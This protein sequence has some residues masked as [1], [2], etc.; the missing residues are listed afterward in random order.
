MA[1][2]AD[3]LIGRAEE[4]DA[5]DAALDRLAHGRSVAVELVGEP[6]IGKT[7]LLIELAGGRWAPPPGARR[8]RPPSWSATCRSR[9]SSTHSTSTCGASILACLDAIDD[10]LRAALAHVLP[11][12]AGGPADPVRARARALSEPLACARCSELLAAEQP[13]VLVL[14]DLHWADPGSFE[15]LLAPPSATAR[16]PRAARARAAPAPGARGGS[17]PRSSVRR[18]GRPLLRSSSG[19]SRPSEARELLPERA[20][21]ARI[22][23]RRERRQPVLP[24]AARRRRRPARVGSRLARGRRGAGRRS[25]PPW[26]RRSPSSAT[27]PGSYCGAPRSRATRSIRS[28]RPPR[29]R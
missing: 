12:L 15:L 19:H 4:L 7:R 8:A 20:P 3:H 25:P 21:T 24:R 9:S 28:S 26:P 18:R 2:A 14:D 17:R 6:G 10:T 13:L 11:S 22:A 23:L 5:V 27:R 1:V 29:R 16:G